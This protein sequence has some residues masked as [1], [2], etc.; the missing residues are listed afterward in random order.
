MMKHLVCDTKI[1]KP[2]IFATT[3]LGVFHYEDYS[4]EL[5]T[6]SAA[7]NVHQHQSV[8]VCATDTVDALGRSIWHMVTPG[9][10][11]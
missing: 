10:V 9:N 3:A 2:H 11:M 7:V 8:Y 6:E 1:L 4:F 5:N